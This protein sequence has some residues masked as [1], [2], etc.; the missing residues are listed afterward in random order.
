METL[1]RVACYLSA[2]YVTLAS[3]ISSTDGNFFIKTAPPE[4]VSVPLGGRLELECEAAGPSPTMHWL[5][6][7]QRIEQVSVCTE[8]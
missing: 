4:H 1:C 8:G 6:N 2:V 5:F 3:L 7:G